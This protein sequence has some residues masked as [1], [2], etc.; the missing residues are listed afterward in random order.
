MRFKHNIHH[1]IDILFVL[2]LFCMFAFSAV[3]LV[4]FGANVYEKTVQNMNHNFDSRTAISYITEKVRQADV[5]GAISIQELDGQFVLVLKETIDQVDY[6]TYLYEHDGSIH[7]L[8]TRSDL[9]FDPDSGQ[10][11][12]SVKEFT[13]SVVSD[14]LF[15]FHITDTEDETVDLYICSHSHSSVLQNE[16]R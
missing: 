10:R 1:M 7:E 8:F 3:V 12:L 14:N 5:D 15:H 4:I 16:W 6:A 9:P 11:I 2:A 13:L